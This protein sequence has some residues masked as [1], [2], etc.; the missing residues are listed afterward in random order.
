MDGF[1]TSS[2]VYRNYGWHYYLEHE[3]NR[4]WER[5]MRRLSKK[6]T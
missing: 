1:V 6:E 5:H 3:T 2:S 4:V